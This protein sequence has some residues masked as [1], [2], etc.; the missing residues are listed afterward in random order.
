MAGCEYW[1]ECVNSPPPTKPLLCNQVSSLIVQQ[2]GY[3]SMTL[4]LQ[5]DLMHP[6]LSRDSLGG[7]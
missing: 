2:L 3:P 4:K 5:P 6:K 7:I 1:V